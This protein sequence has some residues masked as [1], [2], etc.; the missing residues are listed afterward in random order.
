MATV[1]A[2][3]IEC[4]GQATGGLYAG[5]LAGRRRPRGPRLPDRRGVATTAPPCIT[6]T[7]GTG[8]RVD[9]G[10][11]SEQLVYEI[12]D[13]GNY[14]TADVT[15]DFTQV[16]AGGG[17]TRPGAHHRRHR[18]A[19]AGDA[20]GQHGLPRRL[21]RRDPVH[22]HL[23]GR[24]GEVAARASSSCAAG[25]PGA[26]FEYSDDIVEYVGHNSMWGRTGS[27]PPTDP[28]LPEI[29]VRY[30]ARCADA[31]KARKVFTESV[32]LY[33]NGPAG[34]AGVG[35]RP[36]LKELYAHLALPDPARARR[37]VGR[38]AGGLRHASGRHRPRPLRRQ[39]RHLQRRAGRLR[40]RRLRG[41]AAARSPPSGS[42]ST[43]ATWCKGTVT[44]YELP[45]IRSLNF[46]LTGALDGGGTMSLRSD[47][48]G[49]VMYAWL[50]RMDIDGERRRS[51]S[52]RRGPLAVAHPE[53]ARRAQPARPGDVAPPCSPRCTRPWPTTT[54]GRS[55][56]PAEGPAF[57]AGGDLRQMKDARRDARRAGLR[58]AGGHR[59]A[60]PAALRRAQADDRRWSTVRRT[61]AAWA[62]PACATSCWPPS[63][64]ASRCPRSGSACSR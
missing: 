22:L 62:W 37:P 46:V 53:P 17:R 44:R 28:D 34:V 64:P 50:L 5:G 47:H 41:P 16:Q 6:K 57:C 12:L 23:A 40:R 36:P 20:Q 60:A 63:G 61:P 14:L 29:V 4:G 9:I 31:E 26:D 59:D 3:A 11:V 35:T 18:Q 56:S 39:G 55:R 10:T 38:A 32:P 49:K 24:L 51:S 42:P 52:S 33:N 45:G 8:G 13:P 21:R 43:T 27:P 25:W 30:A 48:L 58:L 1:V 54:C 15:A 7:P 19:A 2:H